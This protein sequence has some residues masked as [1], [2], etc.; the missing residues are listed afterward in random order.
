[1]AKP[2][3]RSNNMLYSVGLYFSSRKQFMQVL[4]SQSL[5]QRKQTVK[6]ICISLKL[7][8]IPFVLGSHIIAQPLPTGGV[9]LQLTKSKEKEGIIPV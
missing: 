1:M 5:L 2:E 6:T 3:Q 7:T 4:G 9:Y 8:R